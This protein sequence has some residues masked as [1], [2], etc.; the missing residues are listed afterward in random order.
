VRFD[1]GAT[2]STVIGGKYVLTVRAAASGQHHDH[3]FGTTLERDRHVTLFGE[4]AIR[5][6]AGRHTWVA[7]AAFE[8]DDYDPRDVPRFA[9][10]FTVPGVFVQDDVELTSW[11]SASASARIDYHSEYGTFFS[12]RLSALFRSGDWTARASAGTGFFAPTALTEETE[13]AGLTR[14]TVPRRLLPER[15]RS[16]SI[17][18]TR[19]SG[20]ASYTL[21]LFGS[22]VRNPVSVLRNTSYELVN[23]TSPTTNLGL[24]ALVT[25]R[26][27]PLVGTGTYTYVRSRETSESGTREAAALTPLHS[28]GIVTML[29]S[30]EAGRVGLEIYFT[31]RQ[32]LE[33]NPYRER[34]DSYVIVG[35]LAEKRFARFRVFVNGENLTG[36]RQTRWDPLPR[37]AQSADGRWT[38]D[39][40]APLEGRVI[41][42][43]VRV[44][45]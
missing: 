20:P 13:A 42:G 27:G 5:G 33:A 45:F 12:P 29:E 1:A 24:E 31:G 19:T 37:P 8:R 23:L 28:A 17:D 35:V 26:Q 30:E 15:G 6:A 32:R 7:G 18:I 43:G 2:G 10:T 38:V 3:R 9:Y 25:Y 36:I 11:L 39:A 34:S 21:T 4:A 40:W 14:L 22:R 44:E 41:N 16:A